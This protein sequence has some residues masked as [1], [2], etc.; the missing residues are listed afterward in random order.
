MNETQTTPAQAVEEEEYDY[1]GVYG[2]ARLRYLQEYDRELY[3]SLVSGGRLEAEIR[4]VEK[5]ARQRLADWI[6]H[7]AK[8]DGLDEALKMQDPMKWVGGMNAIKHCVEETIYH[9][10]VYQED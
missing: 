4:Y 3:Q 8:K 1:P 5:A 9:D 2:G 10:L 7:M 6:P